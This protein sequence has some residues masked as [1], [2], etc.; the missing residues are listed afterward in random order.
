VIRIPRADPDPGQSFYEL[1]TLLFSFTGT[2]H[3]TSITAA[4]GAAREP[5][6]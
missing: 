3:P 6:E 5:T 4:S 2:S 1:I